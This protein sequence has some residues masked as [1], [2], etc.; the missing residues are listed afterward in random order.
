MEIIRENDQIIDA[1]LEMNIYRVTKAGRMSYKLLSYDTS[2][3]SKHLKSDDSEES[4]E[5]RPLHSQ[6]HSIDGT[7]EGRI[8]DTKMQI[9]GCD[10]DQ[11]RR[12]IAS[13]LIWKNC[14]VFS[15]FR[16]TDSNL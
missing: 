16:D 3:I 12:K 8:W 9:K 14:G 7:D 10:V 11:I 4:K 13:L 15:V 1:N 5:E 6:K 2:I